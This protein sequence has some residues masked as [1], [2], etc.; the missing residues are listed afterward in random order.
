[1]FFFFKQKTAY[2]LRISDW[3]SGVCSS[4][5]LARVTRAS[6]LETLGEDYVRTARAQVL[7]RRAALWRHAVRNALIPLVTI[8]GLQFSFLLAVTIIIENVFY[9]PGL[10]RLVFQA[11]AQRDLVVVKDLVMLLAAAVVVVNLIVD[12]L[13]AVL[14]PR[15]RAG[16]RHG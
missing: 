3:S 14:D 10:G 4:D 6:V 9:L 2:E 15:L 7:T 16:G 8:M 12:L 5:L 13:Y 11:I 1:M